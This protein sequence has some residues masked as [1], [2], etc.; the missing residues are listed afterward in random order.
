MSLLDTC[1]RRYDEAPV[2]HFVFANIV[3]GEAFQT[4][5]QG[6]TNIDIAIRTGKELGYQGWRILSLK[7][8]HL[9]RFDDQESNSFRLKRKYY[10]HGSASGYSFDLSLSLQLRLF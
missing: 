4:A 3:F 10:G 2:F 7:K 1:L 9:D 5:C 8:E 6:L